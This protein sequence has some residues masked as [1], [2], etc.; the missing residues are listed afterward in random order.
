MYRCHTRLRMRNK[1]SRTR[2]ITPLS[3]HPDPASANA[4]LS[5]PSPSLAPEPVAAAHATV[6]CVRICCHSCHCHFR[7]H[8]RFRT[9]LRNLPFLHC[10]QCLLPSLP[11]LLLRQYLLP[12]LPPPTLWLYPAPASSYHRLHLPAAVTTKTNSALLPSPE[13]TAPPSQSPNVLRHLQLRRRRLLLTQLPHLTTLLLHCR[14]RPLLPHVPPLPSRPNPYYTYAFSTGAAAD[15]T[16]ITAA[17][18]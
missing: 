11:P 2:K 5:S 16:D 6:P 17:S 15:D 12:H 8:L 4:S 1:S 3:P 14:R 13:S 10:H 7:H 9:L 18:S